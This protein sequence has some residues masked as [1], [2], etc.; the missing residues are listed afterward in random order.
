MHHALLAQLVQR[1]EVEVPEPL[2]PMPCFIIT[3]SSE[4]EWPSRLELEDVEAVLKP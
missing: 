4:V 1:L 3:T 2:V